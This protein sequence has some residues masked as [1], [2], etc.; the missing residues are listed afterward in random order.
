MELLTVPPTIILPD[1]IKVML[2]V[3]TVHRTFS[4]GQKFVFIA[5]CTDCKCAIKMFRS[6]FGEREKREIE[7]LSDN[8]TLPGIPTIIKIIDHNNET[9][10][11]E[12]FIDG[13]PL[14]E[15]IGK[16]TRN[17]DLIANLLSEIINIME[18]IWAQGKTHRDLKP[19]NIIIKKNGSPVIID[20]GIFKDADLT[21]ITN[22]GFQPHSW[23]FAAPEQHLGKKEHISYRSDFFALGVIAYYL[24]YRR[25]PFGQNQN[26]VMNKMAIADLSYVTEKGCNLNDLFS[27]TLQLAVSS[28]PR[29][30]EILKNTLPI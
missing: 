17:S 5:S 29:N 8:T 14:N 4:G 9:I 15:I 3:K 11:I 23:A 7:F 13:D 1:D 21:T 16:Y 10:V 28:R 2:G 25:L 6:G 22:T 26:D 20:F 24:Y 12:E 30:I 19:E 27:N 18:P